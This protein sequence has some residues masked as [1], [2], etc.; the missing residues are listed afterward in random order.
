MSESALSKKPLDG[1]FIRVT[2]KDIENGQRRAA[3]YCPIAL[4]AKRVTR[5][6]GSEIIV[7]TDIRTA[8]HTYKT[9]KAACKFITAFDSGEPVEP[10]EF[11]IN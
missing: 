9:P 10:F 3:S 7:G 1:K 5:C 4:A 11:Y 2:R 6:P 8:G